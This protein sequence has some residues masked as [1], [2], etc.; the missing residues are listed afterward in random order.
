MKTF[1][2]FKIDYLGKTKGYP[3]D[4]QYLGECLSI[5]KLYIKECFGINPPPSGTNSAY[6][7]WTNFPSPLGTV[8]EKITNTPTAIITKGCIPIWKPT[9]TNSYGHIEICDDDKA[10]TDNF[11]SVGQNW[12]GR[13]FHRQTHNYVGVVGWLKPIVNNSEDIMITEEQKRI[14]DF[15][16]TRTEGQV[17][18]AFGALVDVPGLKQ[19]ISDQA[20]QI[21]DLNNQ[22][23]EIKKQLEDLTTKFSENE[24]SLSSCQKELKTAN[25]TISNITVEKDALAVERTNYKKWY[26]SKCE[27]LKNLDKMTAWQHIRYGINLLVNKK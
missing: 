23:A 16:G 14:L 8:F 25:Q 17:R 11:V 27:E 3:D 20:K 22:M 12:G 6:G 21:E 2:Q 10:T 4:A 24:K 18:E 7:Y 19:K 15:I 9:A 13:V 1:E 26:E 5:V